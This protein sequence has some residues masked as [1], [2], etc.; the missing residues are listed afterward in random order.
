MFID[1]Q[2]SIIVTNI[3]LALM[4]ATHIVFPCMV[5]CV[6]HIKTNL[7]A[8]CKSRFGTLEELDVFISSW[9]EVIKTTSEMEFEESCLE[10]EHLYGNIIKIKH[11]F[12]TRN[13]FVVAWAGNYLHFRIVFN[14]KRRV[15]MVSTCDIHTKK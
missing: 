7:V 14:Q 6:W 10:F 9:Y 4:N 13:I 15:P 3:E 12:H 1:H 5:L 2:P 8:N 11:G